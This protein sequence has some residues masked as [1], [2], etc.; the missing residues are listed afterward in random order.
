[1][2]VTPAEA[3]Q[4]LFQFLQRKIPGGL[5]RSLI[6]RFIRSGQVRV[7]GRRA[8]PFDRLDADQQVRIPPF[9]PAPTAPFPA[10]PPDHPSCLETP[11]EN[12]PS[13]RPGSLPSILHEDADLLVLNKPSGLPVHGGTGQTM[14]V[15]SWLA[16]RFA[17]APW[18]PTLVH[19]LDKHTTGVLVAA[20]TYAALRGL[21]TLWREG[22]VRKIYLAW[23]HGAWA[24]PGWTTLEHHLGKKYINGFESVRPGGGKVALLKARVL[25]TEGNRSLMLILLHTGRTHQIRAQLAAVG[26]P[27]VGDTAYGG[28]A[29]PR[30]LL[31]AWAVAW[32]GRFFTTPPSWDGPFRLIEGETVFEALSVDERGEGT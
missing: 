2:R 19:R 11:P 27:I 22:A 5:P 25:R 32:P 31:H 13:A 14:S 12:L 20:R 4:K 18:T 16:Q 21:Q 23:V 15:A 7:D 3:G 10:S 9:S 8:S 17:D 26:H 24:A 29:H 1:M 30:L 6:M 28:P